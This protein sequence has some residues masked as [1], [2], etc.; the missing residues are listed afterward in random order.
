MGTMNNDPQKNI[1][2]RSEKT[3]L[4]SEQDFNNLQ[5]QDKNQQKFTISAQINPLKTLIF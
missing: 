3:S 4:F 1:G 2:K 5:N